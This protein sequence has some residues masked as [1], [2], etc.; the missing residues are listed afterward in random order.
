MLVDIIINVIKAIIILFGLLTGFAYMTW[1]ERRFVARIQVRVGPNRVGPAG[2]LQP[3]ADGIKLLFKEEVIPSEVDRPVYNLAPALSMVVAVITF[4]V[5]PVG[6]SIT[7]FGREIPL[8]LADVNIAVLYVLGVSSL[9]VYG[10]VLGGWASNSKYALLGGLRASSQMISYE[11]ALGASLI[12]VLMLAGS[13]RL[14]EIV[15]AQQGVWFIFLQP[16]AFVIFWVSAIA[17]T[18]RAPFDFPEAEQELT[19][20]YHA[21]YSGMRFAMYFMGEYIHM[22]NVS[23]MATTLF[24]GGWRGPFLS[25]TLGPIWFSLKV[26]ILLVSFVWFR[27]TF[28]RLRYDRLMSLGWK[29]LLPLALANVIVTAVALVLK[30]TYF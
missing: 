7:L 9:A 3:L 17:E 5:I 10:V 28:P 18:N 24:L 22:I 25:E 16:L 4:A 2:L 30:D 21:E 6:K 13:L 20:G 12:G 29:V 19:A 27:G 8:H 11:L 23:A 15:D 1:I 14:T 26:L